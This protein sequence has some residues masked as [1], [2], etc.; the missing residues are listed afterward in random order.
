MA[1]EELDEPCKDCRAYRLQYEAWLTYMPNMSSLWLHELPKPP[2]K[3]R[4]TFKVKGKEVPAG[5]CA[6]H[7]RAER[8]RR[9]NH[10]HHKMTQ[11]NYG[12]SAGEYD[13]LKEFQG[14]ACAICQRATGKTKRLAIDHDHTCCPGKTS[15]GECVR[16]LLCSLCNS[17]LAHARDDPTFFRRAFAYLR[18]PP[19]KRK[20]EGID[21]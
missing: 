15:C 5:R 8:M 16:G 4:A 19:M 20:R 2:A 10:A 11:N 7:Y 17:M 14:G 21:L 12:L 6:T 1:D 3:P 9:R 13:E 18:C